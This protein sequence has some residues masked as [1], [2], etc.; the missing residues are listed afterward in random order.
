[1]I[2]AKCQIFWKPYWILLI[3]DKPWFM[4]YFCPKIVTICWLRPNFWLRFFSF[5][6]NLYATSWKSSWMIENFNKFASHWCHNRVFEWLALKTGKIFNAIR[7]Y[8]CPKIVTIFFIFDLTWK[9]HVQTTFP[10]LSTFSATSCKSSWKDWK[11]PQNGASFASLCHNCVVE[12]V[13]LKSM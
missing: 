2:F 1:M 8:F 4:A 5:F 3:V 12:W 6:Y 7:S 11:F 10:L 13:A 9:N